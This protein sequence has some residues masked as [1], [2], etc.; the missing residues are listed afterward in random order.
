MLATLDATNHGLALEIAAIP[1]QIRGFGHVKE[2][3]LAAARQRWSELMQRWQQP[4]A[5]QRAA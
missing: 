4:A 2:R 5:G 3:N 1:D